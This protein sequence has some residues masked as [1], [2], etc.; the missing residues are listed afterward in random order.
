MHRCSISVVLIRIKEVGQ[1]KLNLE[2]VLGLKN[3]VSKNNVF[4]GELK[5]GRRAAIK[6][7]PQLLSD[8][9]ELK[10]LLHL[11]KNGPPHH[12]VIQYLCAERDLVDKMSY[13]ALELCEGDL[14]TAI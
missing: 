5:D 3:N 4:Q 1:I 12:N 13:I 14:E 7:Y 6:R 8:I 9:K 2:Q 11:S 10:I